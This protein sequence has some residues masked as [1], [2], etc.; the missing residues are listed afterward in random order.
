MPAFSEKVLFWFMTYETVG[1]LWLFVEQDIRRALTAFE[2]TTAVGMRRIPAGRI[3]P[4]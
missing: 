3:S 4:C 2:A 1:F